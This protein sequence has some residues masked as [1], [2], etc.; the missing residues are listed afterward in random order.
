MEL[1][2][3]HDIMWNQ[4]QDFKVERSVVYFKEQMQHSLEMNGKNL[5]N[6]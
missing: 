2:L 4:T 3:I 1:V 6:I 5:E